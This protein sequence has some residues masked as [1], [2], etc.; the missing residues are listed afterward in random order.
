MY[1][2]DLVIKNYKSYH[3]SPKLKLE[4]GFNIITGQNNAGKTALLEAFSLGEFFKSV[5]H[6]SLETAKTA[7]SSL[8]PRSQVEAS[9][10]ISRDELLDIISVPEKEIRIPIPLITSEFAKVIKAENGDPNLGIKLRDWLFSHDNYNFQFCLEKR[11]TSENYPIV[12]FP[13]FGLYDPTGDQNITTLFRYKI[14]FDKSLNFIDSNNQSRN[15][16]FGIQDVFPVIRQQIYYFRAERFSFGKCGFGSNRQ[17][18]SNASNLAEVLN[19]LQHNNSRFQRY[20]TLVR[21][22][23]PQVQGISVRP[24]PQNKQMV[25]IL[26]WPHDPQTERDDLAVPL[27]ECGTGIGQVLAILCVVLN[28]DTPRTIII[29]E[30]QSFLHRGAARKLIEILKQYSQHQFIIATHSPTIITAIDPATITLIKQ[31]NGVSTFETL[32]AKD[33]RQQRNYFN[34]LGVKLSDVFGADNILWVEGETEEICFPKILTKIA[35]L[36]LMGTEIKKI[37]STGDLDG[38]NAEVIFEIY[39]ALSQSRSLLPPAIGFIL[40]DEGRTITQKQKLQT[41]GKSLV[42]FTKRR[43]YENYLLYPKAIVEIV[44]GIE[45]F[46]EKPVTEEEVAKWFQ[47]KENESEYNRP[48]IDTVGK[49]WEEYVHGAKILEDLFS[50]LSETRVQYEKTKH[51]VAITEWL[52]DNAPEQLEEL[53][54]LISSIVKRK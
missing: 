26:V 7:R 37:R 41:A 20:K 30:P 19:I 46:R 2:N 14:G 48:K 3:E 12:R 23:F 16:E 6:R 11:D 32:D 49:K 35:K 40:D 31:N 13:T 45:G 29:D 5:P 18:S 44:N 47:N 53:A 8:D 39:N 4:P 52:I 36:P 54:E 25:E 10:N 21:E 1:I 50:D 15:L 34:E 22:I 27:N 42:H 17:L 43:L 51:S 24:D 9:F 33:I 38:R 28:F